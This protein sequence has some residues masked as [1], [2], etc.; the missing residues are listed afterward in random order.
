[1]AT[2]VHHELR[3]LNPRFDSPLLDVLTDLEHLR[4]LEISGDTPPEMFFQLKQIFHLLESLSSARIEG[5]HTTL[6]DYLDAPESPGGQ[7]DH[8]MEIK[9]IE[10]AMR[11]IDEAI[12]QGASLTELDVRGLHEMTVMGLIREGDRSPGSYRS[13]P[14]SISKSDHKPP[15]HLS[16]SGYMAELFAFI[17]EPHQ[18]KYDLM[19]VALA[20]HRFAWIHPFGNGNGRV[21]RLITY[22]ML[23]KYG[24]KVNGAGRLLNPAAVF[25]A[26][27]EKYYQMLSAADAGTDEGL[28]NWCTYVLTGVRDEMG[29]IN[30]L[31][32]YT[33]LSKS[34]LLPAIDHA[35]ERQY[36]TLTEAKILKIA[37][38]KK[39]VK[40]ADLTP[41]MDGMSGG[42]R[43]Y[44]IKKMVDSHLL[45]PTREGSRSYVLGIRNKLLL[46][47]VIKALTNEGFISELL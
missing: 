35:I 32:D 3:L 21:V 29:K 39:E 11:H 18:P 30:R 41:A 42:Q 34:I 27:R 37:V 6:A 13:G 46:R 36:V 4:R 10:L 44:Q 33:Y 31:T 16:V 25:C 23:I 38:N 2:F 17:N 14:I 8:L 26:D 43:T 12:V 1:M 24:F 7:A 47:G 28:E 9:N 20:H 5:N 15:E 45:A 40:S 22:A 19:K